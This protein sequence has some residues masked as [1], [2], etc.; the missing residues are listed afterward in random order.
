MLKI[1]PPIE[2]VLGVQKGTLGPFG[3]MEGALDHLS[4][5]VI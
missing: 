2:S 3:E 4:E 1:I 5:A